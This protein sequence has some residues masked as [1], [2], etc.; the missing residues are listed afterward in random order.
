M[1]SGDV[2]ETVRI[3]ELPARVGLL[4]LDRIPI[5]GSDDNITS[6]TTLQTLREFI[7]TGETGTYVP[8]YDGGDILYIVPAGKEGDNTVNIPI[9]AGR[10]FKLSKDGF[11]LIPQ[12]PN[13]LT[14]NPDAEFEIL[15]TG[16]FQ[17]LTS[18]LI[19]DQRYLIQLFDTSGGS[20]SPTTGGDGEGTT[21][22]RDEVPINTNINISTN[23]VNKLHQVRGAGNSLN[24]RLPDVASCPDRSFIAIECLINNTKQHNI[25]TTGGQY[26]YINDESRTNLYIGKGELAWFYRT[27]DGW[28]VIIDKGNFTNL[29]MPKAAY[30]AGL[31]QIVC[32]GQLVNR[33][34]YPR[35][36]EYVQ[37]LGPSLVT[38]AVWST[39]SA[40]VAGR[41]VLRPYRGC[42]SHGNGTT[43][44]RI[45]DLM[46][47]ALRGLKNVGGS[48][49]E[50][51]NNI[52]GNYQRSEF[53]SHSHN[54]FFE[55]LPDGVSSNPGYDGGSN[56]YDTNTTKTS[57]LTGGTET[58]MDNIGVLWVID[59]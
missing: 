10:R 8:V 47:M 56:H 15:G 43:T 32:S 20:V 44:F 59:Y 40:T 34:D 36:W 54:M 7:E 38:D 4:N 58:R 9:I 18:T 22:I 42:F 16:G 23:D 29:A 6:Y 52:A 39:A 31:N 37:T 28:Y 25:T 5:W 30:K 45:P 19:T 41:T 12:D 49:T 21:F 35:L 24:I 51:A 55:E 11:P 2:I 1:A 57:T 3:P 50:R 53:E 26:I 33:A 14:P 27:E 48:D 17:L 13:P 46:N